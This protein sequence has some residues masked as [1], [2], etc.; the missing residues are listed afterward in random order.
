[1]EKEFGEVEDEQ[2]W[3]LLYKTGLFRRTIQV[4]SSRGRRSRY[5]SGG[6]GSTGIFAIDHFFLEEECVASLSS[7]SLTKKED[8]PS[9]TFTTGMSHQM[10]KLLNHANVSGNR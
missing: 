2:V 3:L 1:M 5:H 6:N 7:Q 8:P 9:G 4:E 10:S